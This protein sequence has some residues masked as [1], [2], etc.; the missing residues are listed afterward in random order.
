[1]W[2]N[3]VAWGKMKLSSTFYHPDYWANWNCLYLFCVLLIFRSTWC[4]QVGIFII[5]V[6]LNF[7]LKHATALLSLSFPLYRDF[8]MCSDFFAPIH[9]QDMS[10]CDWDTR[11]L[12]RWNLEQRLETADA[13]IMSFCGR[14]LFSAFVIK[15]AF[16]NL[17]SLPIIEWLAGPICTPV[18]MR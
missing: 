18:A 14:F 16:I 13:G 3:E 11:D 1:M 17:P 4:R 5:I 9:S 8:N 2:V 10:I 15:R 6:E 7:D 12:R